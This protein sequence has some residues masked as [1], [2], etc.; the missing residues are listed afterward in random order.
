VLPIGL[1]SL[2]FASAIL[3]TACGGGGSGGTGQSPAQAVP[4]R[5]ALL[6]TAPE[7]LS[8]L[9][10][11]ALLVQLNVATNQQLLSLSGPPICGILIYHIEYETVGGAN[12][13]TTA[14]GALMVPTGF[15]ASCTG[16]RP[17]VLYAHGPSLSCLAP[18]RPIR[19][20]RK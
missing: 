10:V 13:P 2:A 20:L 8:A 11:P 1:S 17:V 3:L 5:G 4:P 18:R 16:A 6:Q 19:R 15:G 12:E 7:L 9:T 14:S